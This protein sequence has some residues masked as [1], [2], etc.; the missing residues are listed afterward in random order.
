[1]GAEEAEIAVIESLAAGLREEIL[2]LRQ[3]ERHVDTAISDPRI[4]TR[5]T[6]TMLQQRHQCSDSD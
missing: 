3:G 2:V 1:L 5:T 6:A 4:P